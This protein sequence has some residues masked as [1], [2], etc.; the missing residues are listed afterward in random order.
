[1]SEFIDLDGV[2][3]EKVD[4]LSQKLDPDNFVVFRSFRIP[5][6]DLTV[7]S[8]V[9]MF[10]DHWQQHVVNLVRCAFSLEKCEEHSF[11]NL[12]LNNTVFIF[13]KLI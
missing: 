1:M 7:I 12:D 13:D 2:I 9:V 5:G 8:F 3:I 6:V 10:A 11:E 4:E